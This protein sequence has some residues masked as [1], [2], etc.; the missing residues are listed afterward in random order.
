MPFPR[1]P[2]LIP[3]PRNHLLQ[4]WVSPFPRAHPPACASCFSFSLFPGLPPAHHPNGLLSCWLLTLLQGCPEAKLTHPDLSQGSPSEVAQ[5]LLSGL[6]IFWPLTKGFASLFSKRFGLFGLTFFK[7]F[8]PL[9]FSKPFEVTHSASDLSQ[10]CKVLTFSKVLTRPS[11]PLA[12]GQEAPALAKKGG[13]EEQ[14]LAKGT[15]QAQSL[16][17]A[18]AA[19][20]K[21][22][23]ESTLGK[24]AV[25]VKAAPSPPLCKRWKVMVDWR[26][27][28]K[29]G[30]DDTIRAQDLEALHQLLEKGVGV[31]LCSWCGRTQRQKVQHEMESL[32]GPMV[33]QELIWVGT[34]TARTGPRKPSPRYSKLS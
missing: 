19:L 3:F 7:A 1:K 9:G 10:G 16:G 33:V 4:G 12:K 31:Y 15:G 26:R 30:P 13:E 28:L 23:E 11:K 22:E 17:D 18:S 27:T 32:L 24:G 25:P 20:G 5:E 21:G 29:A 2:C 6:I 14:P 34:T 8:P